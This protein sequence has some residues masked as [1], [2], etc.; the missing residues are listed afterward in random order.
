M[1]DRCLIDVDPRAFAIWDY[2]PLH[3]HIRVNCHLLTHWGRVTHKCV[4]KLT[5]IGSD[6]GLSPERRQP[7]IWTN[8]G[9]LLMGILGTNFIEILIEIQTLSLEKMRLKMSSAKS[10]SFRPGLNVLR[11]HGDDMVK[12]RFFFLFKIMFTQDLL[13]HHELLWCSSSNILKLDRCCWCPGPLR[14]EFRFC[15]A[16]SSAAMVLT[17]LHRSLSSLRDF[18]RD[19]W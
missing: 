19:L 2:L 3:L 1:L 16:R 11:E 14:H 17:R 9:L 5:N 4:G 15:I 7:I 13:T 10:C 6:N 8:A 18:V 12:I